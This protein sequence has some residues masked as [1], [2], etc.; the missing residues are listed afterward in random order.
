[1]ELLEARMTEPPACIRAPADRLERDVHDVHDDLHLL[2][3]YDII[4]FE[5]AGRAKQPYVPYNTVRIEAEFGRPLSDGS[6]SPVS[7]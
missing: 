1:M 7:V 3:E 2:A 4:H 6:E 5:A